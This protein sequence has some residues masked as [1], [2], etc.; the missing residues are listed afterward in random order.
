MF[1]RLFLTAVAV[2]VAGVGFAV[3][4][5]AISV[6]LKD[7]KLKSDYANNDD[8][9]TL[10]DADGKIN[11]YS[12]GTAV[13]TVNVTEGGEYDIL[14]EASCD[15]AEKKNAAMTV[16]VGDEVLKEKLELTTVDAKVYTFTTKLKKGEIKLSIAFTNDVYKEN[17]FDRNMYVHKVKVEPKK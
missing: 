13:A 3:A 4:A 15:A 10:N 2:V 7:F 14:I 16:K 5:D 1:R 11:F 6:E 9:V 12:N 8:G 17:E